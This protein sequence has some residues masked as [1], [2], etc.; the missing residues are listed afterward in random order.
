MRNVDIHDGPH[1]P[2]RPKK[3]AVCLVAIIIVAIVAASFAGHGTA[4]LILAATAALAAA[5]GELVR[6]GVCHWMRTA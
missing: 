2:A 4:A 1:L 3:G 5:V 6:L